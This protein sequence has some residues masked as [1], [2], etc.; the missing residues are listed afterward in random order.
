M[1][2][3]VPPNA[4]HTGGGKVLRLWR[5]LRNARRHLGSRASQ[6]QI[7]RFCEESLRYCSYLIR[8]F[9][10]PE[11]NFGHAMPHLTVM[12]DLGESEILK[13]KIL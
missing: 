7:P 13:G 8:L 6:Q 1:N 11:N 3:T 4:H 10:L 2:G 9:A 5:Q 12:V